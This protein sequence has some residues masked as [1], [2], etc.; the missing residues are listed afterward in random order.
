[1]SNQKFAVAKSGLKNSSGKVLTV[2]LVITAILL[3]SLTAISLFFFQKEAELRKDTEVRLEKTK[4]NETRLE[5]ELKDAKKQAFLLEEKNKEMDE[6]IN[7]LLDDLE[8]EKGLKDGVKKENLALKEQLDA[9]IKEKDS[10][11]DQI[12]NNL[13]RVDALEA[14]VETETGLKNELEALNK[15]LEEKVSQLEKA[16]KESPAPG[17][18]ES[19]VKPE[20]NQEGAPAS[21]GIPPATSL[22]LE[23]DK[24]VVVPPS[25][26]EGRVVNVD[27]DSEFVIFNLGEKDG[28]SVDK[29]MSLYRGNEYLGDIKVTSVQP[30][31]SAAD[32]LPPLTIA[33]VH[34]NDRAVVKQ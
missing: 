25:G 34:K 14:Q 4:A 2:F 22:D 7:S 18:P 12:T 21:Q 31:M 16:M 5:Q 8:V 9:A 26:L 32:V 10:L 13:E 1:M 19:P 24:I 17:S 33:M 28:M 3:I 27:T 6:Q 20:G 15:E 29:I 23:L 30:E 11:Q